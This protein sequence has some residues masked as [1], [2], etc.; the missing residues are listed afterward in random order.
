MGKRT[1]TS[2]NIGRAARTAFAQRKAA[3]RTPLSRDGIGPAGPVAT[4]ATASRFLHDSV[5]K[6]DLDIPDF[7]RREKVEG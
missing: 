3:V 7:L 2:Q 6:D 4:P 5:S 1:G